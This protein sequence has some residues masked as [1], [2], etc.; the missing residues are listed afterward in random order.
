MHEISGSSS[1]STG[2]SDTRSPG[3][4][5]PINADG[6]VTAIQ[7]CRDSAANSKSS[8]QRIDDRRL[9]VEPRVTASDCDVIRDSQDG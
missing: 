2:L 3:P 7:Q 4:Q 9:N 5:R 1:G 6:R 8:A